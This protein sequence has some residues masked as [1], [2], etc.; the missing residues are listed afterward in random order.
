LNGRRIDPRLTYGVAMPDQ[1]AESLKIPHS[2]HDPLFDAIS[3]VQSGFEQ[4]EARRGHH[5]PTFPAKMTRY[6]GY[7]LISPLQLG[8]SRIDVDD[9]GN[10]KVRGSL[11]I[12]FKDAK[13]TRGL[14]A[15]FTSDATI[16]DAP[17]W[18]VRIPSSF[19]YQRTRDLTEGAVHPISHDADEFSVG[20][21][22]DWKIPVLQELRLYG[23]WSIDGQTSSSHREITPTFDFRTADGLA[24]TAKAT[25]SIP[26]MAPPSQYSGWG[27]GTDIVPT[28][29]LPLW[30]GADITLTTGAASVIFGSSSNVLT[31]VYIDDVLQPTDRLAVRKGLDGLF[32]EFFDANRTA[33][34]GNTK[35][36]FRRERVFQ[37]RGQFNGAGELH[38]LISKLKVTWTPLVRYRKYSKARTDVASPLDLSWTVK[39]SLGMKVPLWSNIAIEPTVQRDWAKIQAATDSLFTQFKF[40]IKVNVPIF[41][42]WGR[43]GFVR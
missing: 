16:V 21:R 35:V 26:V 30:K 42:K 36:D 6:G 28:R 1:I 12:D 5:A 10:S 43:D 7:W 31:G 37:T 13:P 34:V 18:A 14:S 40:E 19:D 4:F 29:S 17:R 11:P 8:Y 32:N 22:G 38:T 20:M 9:S 27:F 23:G 3:A 33:F 39:L 41:I 24:A 25:T 15:K 2:E